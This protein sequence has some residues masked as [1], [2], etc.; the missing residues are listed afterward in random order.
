MPPSPR[1]RSI[2]VRPERM[3]NGRLFYREH[4]L[5]PIPRDIP[6]LGISEGQRDLVKGLEF[7]Y[8]RVLALVK[9]N[10]S[11]VRTRGWVEMDVLP[12]RRV[13]SYSAAG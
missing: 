4:D 13:L 1:E 7:D 11:T 8:G 6:E 12:E 2:M 9:V 10:Y 5:I 3:H